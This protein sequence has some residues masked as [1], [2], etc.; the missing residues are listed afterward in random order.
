MSFADYLR[1][2]IN[3][4]E[5]ERVRY[6][7]DSHVNGKKHGAERVWFKKDKSYSERRYKNGVEHGVS[8]IYEDNVLVSEIN[9]TDGEVHGSVRTWYYD[10]SP[11]TVSVYQD[12]D[13]VSHEAF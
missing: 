2:D 10:G 13:C 4:Y 3:Q 1:G 12:G 7:V 6:E 11:R 5:N 8:R 9:H